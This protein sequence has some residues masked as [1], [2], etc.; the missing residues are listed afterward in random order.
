MI[1]EITKDIY[2]INADSNIYFLDFDEK[3][4]I[5][6]G[7]RAFREDI[8][9]LL[10]DIVDLDSIKKVLL[11]HLHYDHIGNF[12]LFKNAKFYASKEEIKSLNKNKPDTILNREMQDLFNIKLNPLPKK[13]KWVRSN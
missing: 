8:E 10:K 2:K 6:V 12:D 11:T 3:T 5:D 13:N 7:N 4:L 1:K 9:K